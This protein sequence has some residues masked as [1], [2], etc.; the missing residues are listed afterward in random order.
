MTSVL[1]V[2]G[3]R[4]EYF[5]ARPIFRAIAE[6]D[7]LTLKL[8]VA[9][10]HLSPMYDH[11]VRLVEDDGF[12]IVDR[13]ESLIHG[14][15]RRS[16]LVGAA[17]QLQSL[18]QTV[19]REKPDWLLAIGD[20]EEALNTAYCGAYLGIPVAHYAAGD[21]ATGN[22]DD[23][24]RHAISRLAH[25]HFT[26]TEDARERLIKSGEQPWRVHMTGH[27]GIDRIRR[28]P[29]LSLEQMA[30]QLGV[31]K[32][33]TPYA[34]LIQHPLSSQTDK[35]EEHMRAT[36]TALADTPLQVFVSHPNSDAGRGGVL[37]ALAE[38]EGNRRF[39]AFRNIPDPL[40]VNLLRNA[41]LM[42]GNSSGALMETA[43]L[44]LAAINVGPRQSERFHGDNVFFVDATA[45]AI[46]AQIDRCLGDAPT[47]ARVAKAPNHF[48]DGHAGENV[49]RLLADTRLDDRFLIKDLTY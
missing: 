5:F 36:L 27:S 46:K 39:V 42:I 13:I 14:D 17:L 48:G 12:T 19:A 20:R 22:V 40:F 35:A 3:I 4:S 10:A 6:H 30:T 25:L 2:T 18:T 32:I 7:R 8:V 21:R 45:P 9:G 26:L 33:E 28:T 24:V 11:S 41:E 1:A 47:R 44:H 49:A 29:A 43:Y 38:V 15:T 16:R 34:V 31:P 23:F 37:K